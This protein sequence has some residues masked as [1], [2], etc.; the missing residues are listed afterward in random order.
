VSGTINFQVTAPFQ[1]SGFV[2]E[3]ITAAISNGAVSVSVEPG[4]YNVV[5]TDTVTGNSVSLKNVVITSG[6]LNLD[7]YSSF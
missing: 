1:S 2:V 6:G 4:T 3:G 5:I 7:T